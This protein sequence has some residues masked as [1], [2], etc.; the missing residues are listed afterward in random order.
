VPR[1]PLLAQQP[2]VRPPLARRRPSLA[3][4]HL[5]PAAKSRRVKT[6][7][8]FGAKLDAPAFDIS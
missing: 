4:V 3:H 2:P 6:L 7:E 5:Y 1:Q 8:A